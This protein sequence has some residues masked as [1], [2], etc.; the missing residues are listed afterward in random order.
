[1]FAFNLSRLFGSAVQTTGVE[2]QTRLAR[3]ERPL[4]IDV[5]T[6]AEFDAGH[7]PGAR[8]LPLDR[9]PESAASLD[10]QTEIV[11]ICRSG[12]RSMQ[13]Y[14]Y[15]ERLGFKHLCNLDGG[16]LDWNGPVRRG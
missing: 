3:G 2:L 13:A 4:L 14:R 1:M 12:N 7:I 16:M 5:R 6:K 8:L 15:L 11:L 10:P 9:L